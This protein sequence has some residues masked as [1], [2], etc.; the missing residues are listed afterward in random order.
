MF[1][2]S[3]WSLLGML[4][5]VI[6]ILVLAYFA[7]RW[8]GTYSTR[9]AVRRNLSGGE[10]AFSVL[11]QLSVGRSERLLLVRLQDKC[12][13]LG[14]TQNSITM[15]REL[16]E[17]EAQAWLAEEDGKRSAAPSFVDVLKENLRKK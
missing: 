8:I 4:A 10:G 15:L 6:G 3:V 7:T 5:V 17:T 1:S 16:D 12:L 11:A 13:L 2:E 9:G 14:V